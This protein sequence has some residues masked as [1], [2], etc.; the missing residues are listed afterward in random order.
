[1]Q[2]IAVADLGGSD[3]A[4]MPIGTGPYRLVEWRTDEAL[5]F[6]MFPDYFGNTAQIPNF[7]WKVVPELATHYTELVTGGSDVSTSIPADDFS[8]LADEAGVATL[9][10]PGVNLTTIIFNTESPFFSDVRT[11]QAI[12][13][14]LDR[15]SM[16]TAVGGGFGTLVTSIVHPSLPEYNGNITPYPYEPETAQTM[17]SEAGWRDEDG[18]GTVEAHG[19]EGLDDGTPFT[20]EIG[21]WSNPLY[22]LPAQIIQQNLA[23]VG[24]AVEINVVDFNVYFSEYLTTSGNP[25]FQFGMSGWF[26]LILP[27]QNELGGNFT[28]ETNDR[29]LWSSERVDE[30]LAAA[31]TVFDD[32]ERNAMYGEVQ[33]ILYGE[34]PWLYLTRLDNLIAYDEGLVI[35]EVGSLTSFFQSI[36]QW[37]WGS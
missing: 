29:H 17:L 4:T 16:I 34:L 31:P 3:Q 30:I 26:N 1:L 27:T 35:P 22:N 9:Q 15:E 8:G 7:I 13:Y 28:S 36:P 33:E 20:V 11:R 2:D 5:V 10:L 25:D 37:T 12:A 24:I 6:E 23:D 18:D 14:A 21:T 19:I 32:A